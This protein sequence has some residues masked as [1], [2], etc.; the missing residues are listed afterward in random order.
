MSEETDEPQL[1]PLSVP[2]EFVQEGAD[3]L[4]VF[5]PNVKRVMDVKLAHTFVHDR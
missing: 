5:N 1:D 2:P 4:V 3:W